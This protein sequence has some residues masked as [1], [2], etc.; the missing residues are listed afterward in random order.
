MIKEGKFFE[1]CNEYV[2]S[3]PEEFSKSILE[4]DENYDINHLSV[5]G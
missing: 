2:L 3:T 4:I 1:V 5:M